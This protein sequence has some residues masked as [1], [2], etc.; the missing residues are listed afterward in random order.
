MT[1]AVQVLVVDQADQ[2]WMFA[3]IVEVEL[4]QAL[5]RLLGLQVGEVERAFGAAQALID[6]LERREVETLLA[7]EVVVD[8]PLVGAGA[9]RDRVD[10]SSGEALGGEFVLR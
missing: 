1:R 10:A 9:A 5:D 7:A 2:L 4:D 6:A 8:H 3:R